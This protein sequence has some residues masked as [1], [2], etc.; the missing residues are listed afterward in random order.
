MAKQIH[1]NMDNIEKEHAQINL[2]VRRKIK[3]EKLSGK[4]QKRCF[5]LC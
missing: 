1:Y 5:T 2:I 4:T 3:W